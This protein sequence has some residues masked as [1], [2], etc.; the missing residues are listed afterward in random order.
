VIIPIPLPL[1]AILILVI[2]ESTVTVS[3]HRLMGTTSDLGFELLVAVCAILLLLLLFC[4]AGSMTLTGHAVV[5]RMGQT[6]DGG[7]RDADASKEAWS[8]FTLS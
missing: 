1:S 2:G 8:E 3:F 7:Q 6:R 4:A 5:I